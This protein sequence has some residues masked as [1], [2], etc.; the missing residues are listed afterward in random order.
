[1]SSLVLFGR[2]ATPA[3]GCVST[4]IPLLDRRA[5]DCGEAGQQLIPLK[6][7]PI[8]LTRIAAHVR[9]TRGLDPRVHLS[10]QDFLLPGQARQ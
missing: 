3:G 9:V 7:F 1:M 5:L 2:D 10:S 4:T 8:G 6:H